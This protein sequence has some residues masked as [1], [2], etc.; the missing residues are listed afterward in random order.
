MIEKEQSI[1]NYL[2]TY[3]L[4]LCNQNKYLPSLSD[5]GGD[6]DSIVSLIEEREVFYCKVYK[7]RTSYLSRELYFLL[8]RYKQ[9]ILAIPAIS[10]DIYNFLYDNGP[11]D[12]ETIKSILMLSKKSF[13]DAFDILLERMLVTATKRGKTLGK[14]WATFVWGTYVDWEKGALPIS[15]DIDDYNRLFRILNSNLTEKEILK[16]IS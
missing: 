10:M 2:N 1:L 15:T 4:L 13:D 8:K 3:G 12:T 6:W 9:S 14:T 16:I 5:V 11:A 7:K